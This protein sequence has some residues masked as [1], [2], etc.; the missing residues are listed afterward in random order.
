MSI[1]LAAQQTESWNTYSIVESWE[2]RLS[3]GV[4]STYRLYD[5]ASRRVNS[6]YIKSIELC[7]ECLRFQ[8]YVSRLA[9]SI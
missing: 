4:V 8:V 3:G 6:T 2:T 5:A 7:A 9:N 1:A